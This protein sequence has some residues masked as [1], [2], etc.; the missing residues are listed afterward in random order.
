MNPIDNHDYQ[1]KWFHWVKGLMVSSAQYSPEFYPFNCF[2]ELD[3]IA[4]YVAICKYCIVQICSEKEVI[5][6]YR[7]VE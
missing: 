7:N 4:R 2:P 6:E 5:Y 3:V 1:N